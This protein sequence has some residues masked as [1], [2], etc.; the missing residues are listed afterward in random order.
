[1]DIVTVIAGAPLPSAPPSAPDEKAQKFQ[2]W[3]KKLIENFAKID[4]AEM[5]RLFRKISLD[6]DSISSVKKK[7]NL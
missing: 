3:R 4:R 2:I 1:M 7:K 5:E 6:F